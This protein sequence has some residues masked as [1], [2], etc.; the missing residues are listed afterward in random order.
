M[1]IYPALVVIIILTQ[2]KNFEKV[3]LA[4]QVG[5][6]VAMFFSIGDWLNGMGFANNPFTS[7]NSVLP[8][9]NVGLAWLLPT[10]IA[11]VVTQ[12]ISMIIKRGK[13]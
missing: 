1:L 7:M 13:T 4:T 10:T 6:I 8:G 5:V 11:I 2:V 3:K 9:G 12:A